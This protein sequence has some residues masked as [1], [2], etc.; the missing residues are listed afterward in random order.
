[1]SNAPVVIVVPAYNE[2][3]S[4]R[5]LVQRALAHAPAVVVDDGS[6][7]GTSAQL[8]GLPV[9]VLRNAQ[10]QGKAHSL[11][12]GMQ[13]ALELGAGGVL[14]L[15]GDGQHAPEDIPRLLNVARRYPGRIV[16]GARLRGRENAPS[17]RRR[18]N[19]VADFWIS[20]AAG[21]ALADTQSGFRYYPGTL[22]QRYQPRLR[23]RGGFVFESE[24][25]I[26]ALRQGFSVVAVPIE[27]VYRAEARPS[28]FQPVA[29]IS[30][31]VIMVAGKLLAWGMY[32]MG[33]W[34]ALR[35]SV[36]LE[37]EEATRPPAAGRA[38]GG[39]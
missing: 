34:R 28:H 31:I 9:T 5:D 11:W 33:L 24:I 39:G 25:L 8:N 19:A 32:P 13:H 30:R 38:R 23:R 15:D 16:I 6:S 7:D 10:N 29:D 1:M 26:D 3:A 22:L 36:L 35:G 18:A 4:I 27:T 20:W 21:Q 37:D 2:A 17:A 12:R 14:T